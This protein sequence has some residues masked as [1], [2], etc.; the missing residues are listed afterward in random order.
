MHAK[1]PSAESAE[2]GAAQAAAQLPELVVIPAFNPEQKAHPDDRPPT[3]STPPCAHATSASRRSRRPSSASTSSTL[4]RSRRS[5]PTA[6]S[7]PTTRRLTIRRP[8]PMAANRG[9]ALRTNRDQ[10]QPLDDPNRRRCAPSHI[11]RDRPIPERR[12][13][14]QRTI[15]D[16]G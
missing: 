10:R 9:S 14:M 5:S 15:R 11:G 6:S 7:P 4:G 13:M 16:T 2:Q 8:S 1:S 3:R 12:E